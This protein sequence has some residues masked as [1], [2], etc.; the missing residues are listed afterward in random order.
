MESSSL[1]KS[2]AASALPDAAGGRLGTCAGSG[3]PNLQG[4]GVKGV[5]VF[6]HTAPIEHTHTHWAYMSAHIHYNY[7]DTLCSHLRAHTQTTLLSNSTLCSP[8]RRTPI[9]NRAHTRTHTSLE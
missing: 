4:T 3:L 6:T 8:V 7:K 9:L 1:C 2:V 5:R